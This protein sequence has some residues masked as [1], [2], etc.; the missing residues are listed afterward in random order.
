MKLT[1]LTVRHPQVTMVMVGLL[2]ALGVSSV[3]DTPRAD[4]RPFPRP[5]TASWRCSRAPP[6]RTSSSWWWTRWKRACRN[7]R[8]QAPAQPGRERRR[9]HRGGVR[10]RRRCRRQARRCH[11]PGGGRPPEAAHRRD[12]ARGEGVLDHQ[13]RHSAAGAGVG[14]RLLPEAR[15][16]GGR[17]HQAAGT[18]AGVKAAEGWGYPEQEVRVSLDVE[19]LGRLGVPP[20]QVLGALAGGDRRIPGGSVS[21]GARTLNVETGGGYRSVG[22]VSRRW[23]PRRARGC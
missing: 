12:Q 21:H 13:R 2:V 17:P 3:L 6:P 11:P 10:G 22:E 19:R 8:H 7:R 9:H 5:H 14:D 23:W 16:P 20:G 4:D 18:G 1:E 15:A